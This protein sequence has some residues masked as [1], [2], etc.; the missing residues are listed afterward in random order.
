MLAHTAWDFYFSRADREALLQEL[1]V[2]TRYP[3]EQIHMRRAD[4]SSLWVMAALAVTDRSELVQGTMI[5]ITGWKR[6]ELRLAATKN[7]EPATFANNDPKTAALCARLD[8]LLRLVASVINPHV[9]LSVGRT[10]MRQILLILEEIKM[11]IGELEVQ[12]L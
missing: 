6:L 2:R 4:G 9:L 1:R 12:R 10:E 7:P 5:D 3:P 8:I 11:L